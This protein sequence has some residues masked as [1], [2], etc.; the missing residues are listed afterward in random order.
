MAGIPYFLDIV[1][2]LVYLDQGHFVLK[3]LVGLFMLCTCTLLVAACST[4]G[5]RTAG[6]ILF[7]KYIKR[8]ALLLRENVLHED[9]QRTCNC[10]EKG[11]KDGRCYCYLKH[12]CI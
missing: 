4:R 12:I 11:N 1:F 2:P 7:L 8:P 3:S 9:S 10:S 6:N 5:L